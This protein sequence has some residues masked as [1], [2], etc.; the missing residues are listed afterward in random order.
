VHKDPPKGEPKSSAIGAFF[1]ELATGTLPK[2]YTIAR[3]LKE[4]TG[5]GNDKVKS[6]LN[7]R[8]NKQKHSFGRHELYAK[9]KPVK[10]SLQRDKSTYQRSEQKAR[11]RRKRIGNR[12]YTMKTLKDRKI[13]DIK[14]KAYD[15]KEK[16]YGLR[17]CLD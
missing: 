13:V 7:N 1:R 12:I 9:H 4:D 10:L 2:Q 3:L 11:R 15:T 6:K 16:D 5:K 17:M 8:I 14:Q